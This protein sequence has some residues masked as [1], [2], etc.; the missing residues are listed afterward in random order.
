MKNL[1]QKLAK[2]QG[3][4]VRLMYVYPS[5]SQDAKKNPL[6]HAR[7]IAYM[8]KMFRS[9][10]KNI[11]TSKSRNVFEIATELYNKGYTDIIMVVGSD[12]VAE[13]DNLLKK[14][15]GVEGN[16]WLLWF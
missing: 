8:K 14:Y 3:K 2:Q 5:H 13:F 10:A 12:R 1:I 6:P 16:T 11:M 9:Y 4:N 15:N 7:K